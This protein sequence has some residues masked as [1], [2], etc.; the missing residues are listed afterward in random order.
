ML[1][2]KYLT[3]R[4]VD[5]MDLTVI[6]A[7]TL[8]ATLGLGFCLGVMTSCVEIKGEQPDAIEFSEEMGGIKNEQ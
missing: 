5:K 3:V 8:L 7:I 4:Q 6:I 1:R 2:I